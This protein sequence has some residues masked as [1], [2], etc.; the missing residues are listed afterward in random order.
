MCVSCALFKPVFAPVNYN[1]PNWFVCPVSAFKI[2][3]LRNTVVKKSSLHN[4]L[5]H[6]PV[7]GADIAFHLVFACISFVDWEGAR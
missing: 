5:A 2:G 6:G 1:A 7:A 3:L 4:R